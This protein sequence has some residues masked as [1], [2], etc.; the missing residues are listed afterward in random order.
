MKRVEDFTPPEEWHVHFNKNFE[1]RC[2]PGRCE[3]EDLRGWNRKAPQLQHGLDRTACYLT[4][5]APDS[6]GRDTFRQRANPSGMRE[7]F[8]G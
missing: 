1:Q 2:N 3:K 8:G 4:D 7:K 5:M 6:D